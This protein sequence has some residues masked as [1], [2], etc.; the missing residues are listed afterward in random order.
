MDLLPPLSGVKGRQGRV[1]QGA[2]LFSWKPGWVL[3]WGL[4]GPEPLRSWIISPPPYAI[5][6]FLVGETWEIKQLLQK[7]ILVLQMEPAWEIVIDPLLNLEKISIKII[8]CSQLPKF[9]TPR[10][11]L[12][13]TGG[14]GE[15]GLSSALVSASPSSPYQFWIGNEGKSKI[16]LEEN[17]NAIWRVIMNLIEKLL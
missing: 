9:V 11:S 7:S 12:G 13:G 17:G 15:R 10:V 16:K 14:L 3:Y 4:I 5:I 8:R 2:I 1:L 6:C